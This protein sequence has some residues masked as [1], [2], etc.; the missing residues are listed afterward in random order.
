MRARC[1]GR[2]PRLLG[3]V[4]TCVVASVLFGATSADAH[5]VGVSKG[6]YALRGTDVA[7][8]IAF[9][10]SELSIAFPELDTDDDGA[11]SAAEIMG[12][13]A[14][15]ERVILEGFV[16]RADATRCVPSLSSAVATEGD[17]LLLRG[18]FVCAG[19]G[20]A[21]TVSIDL[22]I[23][24][25]LTQ[26]HR[27]IARLTRSGVAADDILFV[28]HSRLVLGATTGSDDAS[29]PGAATA[30]RATGAAAFFVMGIE[31]ILTGY[32]HLLFVLA[33]VLV[34]QNA[35]ALLSV[36]TAFTI[37]H[38]I[39]LALATLRIVSLPP[40]VIEP[41]IALSIAYVGVENVLAKT[42]AHRWRLTFAFGLVHGFGFAAALE[43]VQL[44]GAALA[45]ALV[46]F[47]LGVEAGQLAVMALAVPLVLWARKS[48][49]LA[50]LLTPAVS[51]AVAAAGLDWFVV[52]IA[53]RA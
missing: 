51:A 20:A 24:K 13:R 37:A 33:L 11:L 6:D 7:F 49:R 36:V 26:G 22:R 40:S 23:L 3:L 18:V 2:S 5:A 21:P 45:G 15:F 41:A 27:H 43:G 31:H 1:D 8:E 14:I 35:R 50:H 47:N 42:I 29:S 38:S 34:V 16:V 48:D 17:G 28:G 39:T 30:A 12:D 52:R 25:Q 44:R 9:A 46:S 19:S 10:R 4:A 53:H 32:D